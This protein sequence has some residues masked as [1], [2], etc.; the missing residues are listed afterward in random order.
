[1]DKRQR[2]EW[3]ECDRSGCTYMPRCAHYFGFRCKNLG[4]NKI[5]RIGPKYKPVETVG[6]PVNTYLYRFFTG[7]KVSAG[8]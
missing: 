4:G 6:E 1:M 5:P 3:I 2:Q 8:W 7:G